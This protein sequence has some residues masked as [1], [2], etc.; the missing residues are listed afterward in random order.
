MKRNVILHFEVNDD[1]LKTYVE[2]TQAAICAGLDC[3]IHLAVKE[4]NIEASELVNM[5]YEKIYNED[6]IN[7]F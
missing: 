7:N 4:M 6:I 5:L 2:E 1:K 3:I